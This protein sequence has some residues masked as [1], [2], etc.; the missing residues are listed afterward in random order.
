VKVTAAELARIRLLGLYVTE[1]CDACRTVLNQTVRYTVAGRQQVY[2]SAICR[3]TAFFGDR[4]E[5]EKLATP[6]KCAHCGGSLNRRKRGAI[7]C[8]DACWK[9]HARKAQVVRDGATRKIADTDL[10]HSITCKDAN[11][12]LGQSPGPEGLDRSAWQRARFDD[13]DGAGAGLEPDD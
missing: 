10:I 8:G 5:A 12:R 7:Y 6:G 1:K 11:R 9:A 4:R 13:G 2:C 3:D